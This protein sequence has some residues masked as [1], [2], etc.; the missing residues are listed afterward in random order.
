MAF[1]RKD[2]STK[3]N[4]KRR[5]PPDRYCVE[6]KSP[7]HTPIPAPIR[8]ALDGVEQ[9]GTVVEYCVSNH[10]ARIHVLADG[11]PVP[12]MLKNGWRN[13]QVQAAVIVWWADEPIPA[14]VT[15]PL[16]AYPGPALDTSN[17]PKAPP[18]RVMA[19]DAGKTTLDNT[20]EA[21][22]GEAAKCD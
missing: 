5:R 2:L 18:L 13:R 16:P 4:G 14:G 10:W 1:P 20:V 11:R 3:A 7:W 21:A 19:A 9:S 6:L 17:Q 22:D 8:I 12:N 15:Q